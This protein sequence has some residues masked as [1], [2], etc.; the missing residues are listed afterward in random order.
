MAEYDELMLLFQ[1][2]QQRYDRFR[3]KL[4]RAVVSALLEH[5]TP[6]Y[7]ISS[8]VKS[9]DSVRRKLAVSNLQRL[10][11]DIV[12]FRILCYFKEDVW[13]VGA[14]MSLSSELLLPETDAI[15][16]TGEGLATLHLKVTLSDSP[17]FAGLVAECQVRT[18][19]EQAHLDIIHAS[20]YKIDGAD[21]SRAANRLAALAE[22]YDS[23]LSKLRRIMVAR[24]LRPVQRPDTSESFTGRIDAIAN[25][26][27]AL[28]S[29]Q[30]EE[31]LQQYLREHPELLYPDHA[32]CLP[33]MKL[34]DDFVTDFVFRV[35]GVDGPEYVF[36]EIERPS[37]P[38]FVAGGYFSA[39]FTQAKNQLLD[40]E[41]WIDRNSAYLR[42][43]L[44]DLYRPQ[45]H[46]VMGRSSDLTTEHREK[47][48]NEFIG[49][50]R[51]FSTYDDLL[52]RFL[53]I[54]VRIVRGA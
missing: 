33:K 17:E 15:S 6:Y 10:P 23:E 30:R 48:R 45:F 32:V 27:T 1:K 34:G 8:R 39:E 24:N 52:D 49:T 21:I 42:E 26:F 7:S 3:A 19:I 13:S 29:T 44:P 47:L 14:A 2:D 36:V 4:E 50:Q 16:E 12:G 22:V 41:R 51:R 31:Q 11:E 40:W 54:A 38:V 18:L 43:K 37:K 25:D 35:H 28:L 20:I 46:L 53:T 5:G 9:A